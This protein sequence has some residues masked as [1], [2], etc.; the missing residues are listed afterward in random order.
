[1]SKSMRLMLA[2]LLIT[3]FLGQSVS[4]ATAKTTKIKVTLVSVELVENNHVG[5]EWYT[6][7]YVN[8]KEIKEGSTVTLNLK[9]SE[10]V[11]LKA[12]AEEQDKIPDVGTAN[13]SI[14]ASSISKTM[15]KSLT[16]KV[17]ENRG[18]YSGNTAEWKFTFKIQK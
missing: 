8:G 3:V 4:A 7:G 5:N 10:S 1:M 18:R 16:V 6:A 13:L 15:N 9:S 12:Y 17:K 11:K 14:K 2:F